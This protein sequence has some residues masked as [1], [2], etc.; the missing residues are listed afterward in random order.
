MGIHLSSMFA[1]V[2]SSLVL[3][4]SAA[5]FTS[6]APMGL[7]PAFLRS[8]L[9]AS[10]LSMKIGVFYGT[11]T[12]N[13]EGAATRIAEKLGAAKCE[14]I[15]SIEAKE[16]ATYDTIIVGA[17][18]WHTGEDKERTP[19]GWRTRCMEPIRCRRGS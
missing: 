1:K 12:G 9:R 11:S 4:G 19:P 15:G 8:V 10:G 16:L 13:T 14:D 17:P 6:P 7:K 5:A 18:T 3:V 2:L